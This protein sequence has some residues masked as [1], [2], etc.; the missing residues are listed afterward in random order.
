MPLKTIES[1]LDHGR[2]RLSVEDDIPQAKADIAVLE[3]VGIHYDQITQQIVLIQYAWAYFTFQPGARI[4]LPEDDAP[5]SYRVKRA[6]I[7]TH[8]VRV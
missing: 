8:N 6:S 1:F 3:E 4:I 7:L 2:V 5:L